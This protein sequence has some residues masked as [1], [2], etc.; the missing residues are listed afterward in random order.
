M[1]FGF[2]LDANSGLLNEILCLFYPT[3]HLN[4]SFR[5]G[6]H[7]GDF[8]HMSSE[9]F[10]EV[11]GEERKKPQSFYTTDLIRAMEY[12]ASTFA[13]YKLQVRNF[14]PKKKSHM[15]IFGWNSFSFDYGTHSPLFHNLVALSSW[16]RPVPSGQKKSIDGKTWSFSIF[17]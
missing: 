8:Q 12:Q 2:T 10:G 5:Q 9:G 16:N 4:L 6:Q 1:T 14:Y 3:I 15:P 7:D 17:R 11:L 13:Y